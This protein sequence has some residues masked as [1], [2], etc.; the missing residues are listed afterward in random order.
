MPDTSLP[1][2]FTLAEMSVT[3]TGLA[4]VPP[5][6][7]V[8]RL[9]ALA[10]T[11][12]DPL[13]EVVGKIR[14]TSGYRSAAVNAAVGGSSSSQHRLGEAADV[15]PVEVPRA[16]MWDT[17][18]ERVRAGTLPVDEAIVYE[19]K[20]HVHISTRAAPTAS[21]PNRGK[22]LVHTKSGAYVPWATY[23]GPLK[24]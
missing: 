13:R 10:T 1:R 18:V 22:L 4:N 19:D 2:F 7:A 5:P 8:D 6:D 11:V 15:I 21:R 9:R 3:S 24:P 12:L 14:V 17:I 23:V 20:P 16:A